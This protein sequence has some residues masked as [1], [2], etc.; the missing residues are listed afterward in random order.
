[1]RYT[2]RLAAAASESQTWDPEL[3]K[4]L[5][6]MGCF[7]RFLKQR[8]NSVQRPSSPQSPGGISAPY[9][10]L[11]VQRLSPVQ[12]RSEGGAKGGQPEPVL[13]PDSEKQLLG[14]HRFLKNLSEEAAS[15]PATFRV[16][17]HILATAPAPPPP[18]SPRS[19][20][21]RRCPRWKEKR[22]R[23]GGGRS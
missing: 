7:A 4:E 9:K 14:S 15:A 2:S 10:V 12:D 13:L 3:E 19:R 17:G 22:W 6:K 8:W 20:E 23:E 21:K 18:A 1:M 11:G 16:A 5:R